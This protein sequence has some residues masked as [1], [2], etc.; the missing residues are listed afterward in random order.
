MPVRL[1]SLIL[2]ALLALGAAGFASDRVGRTTGQPLPRF[3]SLKS[4]QVNLR[5]GPGQQYP[6]DWVFLRRSMPVEVLDEFDVWRKIRDWEGT[7]GWVHATFLAARRSVLVTGSTRPLKRSDREDADTV[8]QAEAG[9]IGRLME[10]HDSWCRVEIAGTRGWIKRAEIWGVYP[11]E[12][13]K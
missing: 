1:I 11:D 9:V 6:V 3:V 13:V 4:S 8:A 12:T 2:A 10:C 7:E 5:S